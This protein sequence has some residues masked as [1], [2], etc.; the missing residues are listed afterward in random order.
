M[1]RVAHKWSLTIAV[2]LGFGALAI[3]PVVSSSNGYVAG[4]VFF[5]LLLL[6]A[7]TC[8]ILFVVGFVFLFRENLLGLYFLAAMIL[9]PTGFVG[10]A[11]IAKYLELGAYREEAMEPIVPAVANKV[12]FKKNATFDD[13]QKLWREVLS[14]P[15][16]ESE[17]TRP[18]IQS[19]GSSLPV[20]GHEVVLFS[21]FTNATDVQKADVKQ[22]I[23]AY[24]P[25]LRYLENVDT[26]QTEIQTSPE[27]GNQTPKDVRRPNKFVLKQ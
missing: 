3:I 7:V 14:D 18:G 21:F 10:S 16:G 27:N 9:L 8:L 17:R 19:I 15:F 26:T 1:A 13:V 5:P 4:Y 20:E 2:S 24:P 12:I 11:F 23:L 25:V 22:R 6:I